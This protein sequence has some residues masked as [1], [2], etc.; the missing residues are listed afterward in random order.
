MTSTDPQAR[1]WYVAYVRSCME[2]KAAEMLTSLG[3]ECYLPVQREIRQWSDRKKV[4]ERLVLPRMIFI[5]CDQYQ[6]V[7]TLE[8]VPYLYRYITVSGAFTPAVIRDQEM[9]AFRA[10]VD[11]SGR[12]VSVTTTFVPGDNVRVVS[13]PLTGMQCKLASVKGG[14]CLAVNLGLLGTATVELSLD[15]IEKI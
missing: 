4:C 11:K 3:Y 10:M 7:R 1:H 6:R 9:D 13:G 5:H 12:K 15:T 14:R 8:E 2:R